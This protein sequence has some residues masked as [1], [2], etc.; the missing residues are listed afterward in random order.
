MNKS[1]DLK[2]DELLPLASTIGRTNEEHQE[3]IG[4]D[5]DDD[6]AKTANTICKMFYQKHGGRLNAI[7]EDLDFQELHSFLDD[8]VRHMYE[9]ND[10]IPLFCYYDYY[11]DLHSDDAEHAISLR[12]V[13]EACIALYDPIAFSQL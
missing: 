10:S 5:H 11:R 12:A 1:I 2:A 4:F 13:I 6:R 8:Y 9:V 7:C 3:E